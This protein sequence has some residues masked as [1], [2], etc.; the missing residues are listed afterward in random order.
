MTARR[1]CPPRRCGPMS[2]P[3]L[4]PLPPMRPMSA[5]PLRPMSAPPLPIGPG[6]GYPRF[7][8][9]EH[10][11]GGFG[12]LRRRRMPVRRAAGRPPGPDGHDPRDALRPQRLDAD[13]GWPASPSR[14]AAHRLAAAHVPARRFGSGYDPMQVDRLFD[15]IIA[16]LSGRSGMPLSENE[17]D[18]QPVRPGAGR[19]LRG[20]GEPALREVRDI[21]RPPLTP[22]TRK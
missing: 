8:D 13:L 9:D 5:P 3:P 21:L 16:A 14:A 20:R 6:N 22:S 12:A 1:R 4:P 11:S 15:A 2:A 17:L 19:L 18:P 7:D 10:P